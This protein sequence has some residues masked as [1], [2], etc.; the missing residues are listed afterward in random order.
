MEQFAVARHGLY[1]PA[2]EQEGQG[3]VE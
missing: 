3:L 1:A 2:D